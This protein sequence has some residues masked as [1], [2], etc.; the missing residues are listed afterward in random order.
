M[1]K[2][3][4]KG[5]NR[6]D[7]I[8][9]SAGAA[10][11]TGLAPGLIGCDDESS[12]AQMESRVFVFNFLHMD[13]SAHDFTLVTGNRTHHLNPVT[14]DVLATYREK[15]PVLSAVPDDHAT[16]HL[17]LDMP[18][19]A[20]QLCYVKRKLRSATDGS[21]DMAMFFYHLPSS[22]LLKAHE[23]RAA[24]GRKV[25]A[26]AKWAQYGI[27][28]V[29]LIAR[30]DPVG[31]DA[32][33]DT[34]DHAI[35]I[36]ASH[37]ELSSG[38]PD[39][40][41]HIQTNVIS[42]QSSTTTLGAMLGAQG[43]AWATQIKI[44]DS[45]TG[46]QAVHSVTGDKQYMPQWSSLTNTNAGKAIASS[47]TTAKD[48]TYLGVNITNIDPVAD[49]GFDATADDPTQGAIWTLHDGA[50]VVDQSTSTLQGDE[51]FEYEFDDQTPGHGYSVKVI[52]VEKD[53]MGR[54]QIGIETK[55]WFVR[56]LGQYV[57]FLNSNREPIKVKDLTFTGSTGNP[58]P[59]SSI[60]L[61]GDY[62]M[63]VDILEPEFCILGMPVRSQTI[64]FTIPM[65][66]EAS[67]V[68]VMAGGLGR[69][70]VR[71]PATIDPGVIMTAIFNL[72]VPAIFLVLAA[73]PGLIGLK[74]KLE[75][76]ETLLW[77]LEMAVDFFMS[78][79]KAL[80]YDEPEAFAGM[81]VEIAEKLLDEG[82]EKLD[83]LIAE[84]IMEGEAIEVIEDSVPVI[85][86]F[87]AAISAVGTIAEL[88]ETS[89]QV[90]QS[91]RTYVSTLTFTH[92]IEV[93]INH[94]PDHPAGFPSVATNY[95]VSAIFDDG[96]PHTITEEMP[97]TTVTD[98]IEV[99]FHSVPIGGQVS[100]IVAF[101]SNTGWLAGR[102][103][104]GPISNATTEGAL[105]VEITI[106]EYKVKLTADT[107]Y[108]HKEVIVL[109]DQG[110]HQW[111]A[112]ASPPSD[113]I[114]SGCNPVDGQLCALEGITISTMK[115]SVGYT[116]KAYN[117]AVTNCRTG[118]VG[119]VSQF[120]NISTTQDPES[121]YLFSGCG[122]S[123]PVRMVYDLMGKADHNYYVDPI[124][125]SV[126]QI[127]LTPGNPSF[128]D[129]NS[130][131]SWGRFSFA[132]DALLLHPAGRLVSINESAN[133]I[134]VLTLP[135]ASGPDS[136]APYSQV[137]SGEGI[138]EG[139]VNG[140]TQA[141]LDPN[142]TILIL[143]TQNNRIQAFDL[144]ANPV[145]KFKE[146]AYHVPL[147]DYPTA[148]LDLAVEYTGYMY[149][150][151]YTDSSGI[152]EFRLDI[153]T[154]EGE[155]L[156]STP[157]FTAAKLS[158]DY[159]RDIFAL[160]YQLLK[161]PGDTLPERTEPSVSH[162]I[163]STPTT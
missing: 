85:G 134:E 36:V 163:P 20:V 74:E 48:D 67:Y 111:E 61:N 23:I 98:P 135:G 83:K 87:L 108:N 97:G 55:N 141:V 64:E 160:N 70:T 148:Y 76:V 41:A 91:P 120:A 99:T 116:W 63:F 31:E 66:E 93:T 68:M 149:V 28:A 118:S 7:F 154:P 71:Y 58:F 78:L 3:R 90:A 49:A 127:R 109:D 14:L 42:T 159:W 59:L 51:G 94:D 81:G 62:D 30:A 25:L 73:A 39:S 119:Q 156:A 114:P 60:G 79:F 88:V 140:P 12:P 144:G 72:S 6:R 113:Q 16:H 84:S 47:L 126:R 155:F 80:T 139:L 69:G 50:P 40:A 153:Y 130:N 110:D 146:G 143:E 129:S 125:N 56:Y 162:W 15:H 132:S 86:T 18:A 128:D 34:T 122:F 147:I 117:Q 152:R 150:L 136:D 1:E 17:E 102:G 103:E 21:W 10:A 115:A 100:F 161:L 24:L 53:S 33:K 82:A 106:E 26:H 54:I 133:K 2:L 13:P 46:E 44:M 107:A 29:D 45:K 92:D 4:E 38:D 112:A 43:D 52:E 77:V 11:L 124:S 75:K 32:F 65:P 37:P 9:Y 89:C 145:Q 123:G 104:Y 96:T 95:T 35:A 27:S 101:Y 157:G 57:R 22:A 5:V 105:E 121:E 137:Y 158:V 131:L 151:S 138:R 142:G 19:S 8:K